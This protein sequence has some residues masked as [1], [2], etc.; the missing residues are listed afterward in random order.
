MTLLEWMTIPLNAML[1]VADRVSRATAWMDRLVG[2]HWHVRP[3]HLI[4]LEV[5]Y[6]E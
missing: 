6:D 2:V 3:G 5:V 4:P 1:W